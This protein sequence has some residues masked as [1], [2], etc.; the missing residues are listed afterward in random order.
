MP[1]IERILKS[2]A[3]N[4]IVLDLSF[5][6]A[7]LLS[8]GKLCLHIPRTIKGLADAGS[9]TGTSVRTFAKKVCPNYATVELPKEL[10]A[11][12]RRRAQKTGPGTT[13]STTRKLKHFNYKTYKFH[14]LR[15]YAPT[16]TAYGSLDNQTA[17]IVRVLTIICVNETDI[18]FQGEQEH[19]HA[20]REG[21]ERTNKVNATQQI[22]R[23]MHHGEKMRRIKERVDTARTVLLRKHT[24]EDTPAD[25]SAE[26]PSND[27]EKLAYASPAERYHI[28]QS[29]RHHDN[30]LNWV[31]SFENDPALHVSNVGLGVVDIIESIW[32]QNFYRNLK[33]HLLTRL[34]EHGITLPDD[35]PNTRPPGEYSFYQRSR[36]VIHIRKNSP[37]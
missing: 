4:R 5:D 12:S 37:S 2:K 34:T 19:I 32:S 7:T 23:R 17:Q 18:H 26:P 20:K 35:A 36:L 13:T 22:A 33:D 10:A 3:D 24:T 25:V 6:L 16:V 9:A 11:R 28:A 27:E 1:V 21:W 8:L 15:D 14:S 30:I 29:Q 31:A